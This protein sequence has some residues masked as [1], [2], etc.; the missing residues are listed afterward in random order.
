[1]FLCIQIP[2]DIINATIKNL[3]NRFLILIDRSDQLFSQEKKLLINEL[4][5]IQILIGHFSSSFSP[6]PDLHSSSYLKSIQILS[7]IPYDEQTP[8]YSIEP[9][10]S[11]LNHTLFLPYGFLYLSNSS[12]DYSLTHFLLNILSNRLLQSKPFSIECSIKSFD[13]SNTTT[14][15]TNNEH[16]VYL[17]FRS[18][19]LIEQNINLDEYLWPFMSANSL[20]KQF[21]ITYTADNYCSN[22]KTYQVFRN[23]TYLIDDVHLTF[24]CPQAS[25][26]KESKCTVS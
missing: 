22:A 16:I 24:H 1:L 14:I 18:K 9:I 3:I 13:D 6:L 20:M 5:Q 19:F 15:D 10:Y 25:S 12:I 26:I 11:P 7:T 23:N 17:L 21:L 8:S 4:N 2:I